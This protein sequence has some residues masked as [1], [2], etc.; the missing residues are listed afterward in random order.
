MTPNQEGSLCGRNSCSWACAFGAPE[1]LPNRFLRFFPWH[2]HKHPQCAGVL[3]RI[4]VDN[5]EVSRTIAEAPGL[6]R[7][8]G[9]CCAR[10]TPSRP[11]VHPQSPYEQYN[12]RR[13]EPLSRGLWRWRMLRCST[14]QIVSRTHSRL[15]LRLRFPS[16]QRRRE[17]GSPSEYFEALFC[18]FRHEKGISEGISD[19]K[20]KQGRE[21]GPAVT[22]FPE[23][24]C[25]E[26]G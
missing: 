15:C 9:G 17:I 22:H 13:G 24:C 11:G 1:P 19:R 25:G 10:E 4:R 14:N 6:F 3:V 12:S 21:S 7:A 20:T 16:R 18:A 2:G 23:M 8:T 5:H 26:S